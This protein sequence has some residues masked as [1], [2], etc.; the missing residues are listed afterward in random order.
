MHE[1]STHSIQKIPSA[2]L[3]LS[4]NSTVLAGKGG[5]SVTVNRQADSNSLPPTKV[6]NNL[7]N[8]QIRFQEELNER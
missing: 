3:D 5:K 2:N 1:L 6:A 7:T 4:N 8:S